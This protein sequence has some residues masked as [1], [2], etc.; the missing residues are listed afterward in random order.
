[1]FVTLVP[2]M[3]MKEKNSAT[4]VLY[5]AGG[6]LMTRWDIC[7]L[8]KLKKLDENTVEVHLRAISVYECSYQSMKSNLSHLSWRRTS[9]T[10]VL[11][12]REK[13]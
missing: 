11:G 8:K 13:K 12:R 4:D 6:K 7:V 2:Y 3:L 9:T 5:T 1:M 10:T